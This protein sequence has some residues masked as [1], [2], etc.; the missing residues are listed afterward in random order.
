MPAF[1]DDLENPASGN[2]TID[3]ISG[4]NGWSYPQNPNPF[5]LDAQYATS[6]KT[7]F[8]GFDVPRHR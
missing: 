1:S 2:W 8:W 3:D 7:N 6:G 4:L 5:G